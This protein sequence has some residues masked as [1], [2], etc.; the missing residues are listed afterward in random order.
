M[1]FAYWTRFTNRDSKRYHT[2]GVKSLRVKGISIN[3]LPPS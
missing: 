2:G 3:P 1:L